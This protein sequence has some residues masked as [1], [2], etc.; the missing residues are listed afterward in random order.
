MTTIIHVIDS[1]GLY[2]AELMLLALAQEQKRKGN[3]PII[4]S[5]GE[6]N[7]QQKPIETESRRRGIKVVSLR[8]SK[9]LNISGS[10]KILKIARAHKAEIIHSHGYKGDILLGIIPRWLHDF[11]LL[12]T[13]HGWTAKKKI[14]T[15]GVY[16][17]ADQICLLNFDAIVVVNRA[18]LGI[19]Y[20]KSVVYHRTYAINNGI[21]ISP[22]RYCLTTEGESND[23]IINFISQGYFVIAGIGRLSVEKAFH[24]LILALAMALKDQPKLGLIIF[25]DGPEKNYLEKLIIDHQLSK[26]VMLA[27]YVSNASA[28]ISRCKLVAISSSTEGLPLVLLEAM[29][30]KTPVVATRVG[31]IPDILNNEKFG[32][33]IKPDSPTA[34][35]EAILNIESNYSVA[36]TKAEAAHHQLLAHY[37]AATMQKKYAELYD[38]ILF[39]NI[40]SKK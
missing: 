28:Y 21:D 17:F 25:G 20:F 10:F 13:V 15:L 5:I 23:K 30:C 11:K 6:N 24:N 26:N 9:G 18:M 4:L 12:A 3:N 2:G 39:K 38:H 16:K 1:A 32:Y 40:Q 7:S 33:T 14:S 22:D 27:G 34:I 19:R 31:G 37:S 29:L 35:A 8:M 36:K